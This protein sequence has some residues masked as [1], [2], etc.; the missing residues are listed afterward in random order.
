MLQEMSY[1]LIL[2]DIIM[3]GMNGFE[4]LQQIKRHENWRHIPVIVLSA[5]DEIDSIVRCVEMGAED[6]IS[7]PFKPVLLRA[8]IA[9]CLEKKRLRDQQ[10]LTLAQRS[11]AEATPVPMLISRL[12]DGAILYANATAGSTFGLPIEE[13]LNRHTQDFYFDPTERQKVLDALSRAESIQ[14]QELQCQRADGTPFWVIASLQPL[15]FY[16]E[17]TV[18]YALCN[19]TDRK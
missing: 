12:S 14:C 18:L 2:L 9:A 3:P 8:K 17:A 16:G 7:K 19:I 6:Y 4:V 15:T 11:I 13:L 10:I 5:L 1:D